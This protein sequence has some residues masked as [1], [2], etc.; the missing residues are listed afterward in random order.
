MNNTLLKYKLNRPQLTA[1]YQLTCNT[2]HTYDPVGYANQVTK[3]LMLEVLWQM[4]RLLCRQQNKFT[5]ILTPAQSFAWI[6]FWMMR[7]LNQNPYEM[8]IIQRIIEAIQKKYMQ[9]IIM[10]GGM[11]SPQN[12]EV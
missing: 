10:Q 7:N 6:A 5:L 11:V 9:L 8:V 3:A 2:L 1:L 12:L 4:Q